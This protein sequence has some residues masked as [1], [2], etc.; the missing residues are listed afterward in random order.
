MPRDV[1]APAEPVTGPRKRTLTEK[2]KE[3]AAIVQA[4]KRVRAAP[5]PSCS[6][7]NLAKALARSTG[8]NVSEL[9]KALA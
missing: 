1:L 8:S 9:A 7:A 3:A 4:T 2:A 6:S 5:A